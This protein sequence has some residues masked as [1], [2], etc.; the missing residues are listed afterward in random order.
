MPGISYYWMHHADTVQRE[1]TT[2]DLATIAIASAVVAVIVVLSAVT[3]YHLLE[4]YL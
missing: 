3:I 1:L 2:G 4:R